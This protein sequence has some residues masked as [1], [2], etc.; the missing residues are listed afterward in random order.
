MPTTTL[1]HY[2]RL[3]R[4][5]PDGVPFDT[6]L[7]WLLHVRHA[8]TP[9]ILKVAKSGVANND[10]MHAP[11]MLRYYAGS[12]AVRLLR[13]D[14]RAMLVERACGAR[15]LYA[16]TTGGEDDRHPWIEATRRLEEPLIGKDRCR[17]RLHLVDHG[18]QSLFELALHRSTGL[19][20]ADVE[21]AQLDAA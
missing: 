7:N 21:R 17:R 16:M 5:T 11:A 18:A 10:E 8:G 6:P 13:A 3:W 20:Q 1:A 9:A 14:D 12:G 19:H 4:L 15:S 2:T